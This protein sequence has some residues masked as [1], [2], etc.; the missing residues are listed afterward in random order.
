MSVRGNFH[1]HFCLLAK[2]LKIACGLG[3]GRINKFG[4]P[5]EFISLSRKRIVLAMSREL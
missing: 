1:R 5:N 4:E 3:A 2:H